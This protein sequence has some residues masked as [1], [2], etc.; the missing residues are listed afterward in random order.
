VAAAGV[1]A[2]EDPEESLF[3]LPLDD[4][5]LLE[6]LPLEEASAAAASFASDWRLGRP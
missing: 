5:S 4:E 6:L 3:S 1:A 2:S